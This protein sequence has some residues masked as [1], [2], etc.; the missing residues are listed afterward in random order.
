M[1]FGLKPLGIQLQFL[2]NNF[3][4]QALRIGLVIDR[5]L[6]GPGEA[7]RILELIDV[8]TEHPRKQRMEGADPQLFGHLPV[9]T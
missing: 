8:I 9:D 4:D 5:K 6:L 7:F 1:F 3:L 2:G